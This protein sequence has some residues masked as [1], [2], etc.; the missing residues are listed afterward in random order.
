MTILFLRRN[1]V[2][3]NCRSS[4][5][6]EALVSELRCAVSIKYLSNFEDLV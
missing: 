1:F 5:S 2:N 4:I 6:D 3:S